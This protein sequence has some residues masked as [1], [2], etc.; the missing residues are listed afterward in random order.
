MTFRFDKLTIKAQEAVAEA[1]SLAT[2]AGNPEIDPLHLLSALA[3]TAGGV[4]QPV[5]K[6]IGV[7]LARLMGTVTSE[8]GRLPKT[9]G[10]RQP[11]V[12]P[13]LQ[14]VFD[15]AD[16]QATAM[17]DEYISSEHLLLGLT[18]ADSK[19]KNLLQL[20]GVRTTDFSVHCAKSVGRRGSPIKTL[21]TNTRRS[22]ATGSTWSSWPP[23]ANSIL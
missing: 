17:K 23:K 16:K 1:Q 22:N 21:K 11:H 10:G 4:V 20:G 19:A 9:S 15:A 18:E 8:L 7:D 6:K 12:S 2:S 5:L 3:N 13:G 14:Q